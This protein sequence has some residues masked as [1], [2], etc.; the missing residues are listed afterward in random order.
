MYRLGGNPCSREQVDEADIS[1]PL[2]GAGETG[3]I[4]RPAGNLK[5]TN[6]PTQTKEKLNYAF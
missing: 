3:S 6:R 4:A 1:L 2:G 5:K